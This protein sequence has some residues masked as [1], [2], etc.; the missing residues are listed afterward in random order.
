MGLLGPNSFLQSQVNA[1]THQ[2]KNVQSLSVA[3]IGCDLSRQYLVRFIAD[4][5]AGFTVLDVKA[6][7]RDGYNRQKSNQKDIALF[8]EC[9]D[10]GPRAEFSVAFEL[11][12]HEN[13]RNPF[14]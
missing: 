7:L 3:P 14:S 13:S 5:A 1:T 4:S 10:T 9:W 6:R 12:D 8:G 2:H 11:R